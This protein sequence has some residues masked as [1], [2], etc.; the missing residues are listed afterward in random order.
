MRRPQPIGPVPEDTAR[1]AQAL[2]PKGHPSLHRAD[3]VGDLFTDELFAP[4]F[5][6]HGQPA[7]APWR[8]ALVTI[9]QFA[10][11]LWDLQAAHALR[12]R[13]DWTDVARLELTDR[14]VAGC[15]LCEF[16]GRLRDG[17]AEM[18][19]LDRLLAWCR[20]RTLLRVRGRQRTDST[21]VRA[22]VRA[23]NR[24]ELVGDTMRH[25]LNSLAV[26]APAWV[27]ALSQPEWIERDARRAE[28]TRLPA[29]QEARDALALAIGA[30]GYA[31]L[32][33]AYAAGAPAWLRQVPAVETLRR[34]WVQNVHREEERLRWRTDAQG[35]PPAAAFVSSP[36][37]PD[38]H[39]AKTRSTPWVGDKIHVRETC[40][41]DVP[42]LITQVESATGPT[43]DGAA[44]PT[45]HARLRDKDLLP[46]LHLVETGDLD[47]PLL[48]E[49]QRDDGVELYGP[50]RPDL[51][52]QAKAGEGFDAAHFRI[53]W[54][55]AQASCPEG[56]TNISWTPAIDNRKNEVIKIK[57]STTDCGACPCRTRCIRSIKKDQRRTS[58]I[59]PKEAYEALKAGRARENTAEFVAT[60]AKRAGIE[61]TL[62]RGIR[63]CRL[64]RTR[65][66]GLARVHLAHVLTAV[67][68]NVLR[69]G[70]WFTEAPRAKTRRS[71]YARLMADA[72][73]A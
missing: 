73:A 7:L 49:S 27:Q 15:V 17:A 68:I 46:G 44:T 51:T 55:R 18:L 28:Q 30:D 1:V 31:L 24:V 57:F 65:Y 72:V 2:F 25:A 16:R 42:H 70:E 69:L 53:D 22:A 64:R 9:L 23:L 45:I 66:I 8:L 71:P 61:G 39:S 19:L 4:L 41:E 47:G 32:V 40:E 26:V 3:D 6:T 37:D 36:D 48:A 13:I 58:T 43:A 35:I 11:G 62:S 12:T 52:W 29:G 60:Y 20:E 33:A 14:G 63:R 38:A 67:A 34:V 54:E 56:R 10:D 21:H 59:R 5:P 50:T